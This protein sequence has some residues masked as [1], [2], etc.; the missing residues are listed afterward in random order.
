MQRLRL[1]VAPNPNDPMEDIR[2]AAQVRYDIGAHSPVE[3]DP[4]LPVRR[5]RPHG[6]NRN[7]EREVYFEFETD[8]IEE[9]E[10]VLQTYGHSERV[11][12]TVVEEGEICQNC[13]WVAEGVLPT[14]CRKCG[15]RDI[16]PCPHCHEEVPRQEYQKTSGDL[17]RCPRCGAQVR[18]E[19]NPDLLNANL[20]LNQPVVLVSSV[21][22]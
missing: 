11:K 14:I 6:E 17:F 22:S 4:D 21:G 15:H 5:T 2:Y 3:I 20:T 1:T 7:A 8:L 19:L 10:H 13:G 12:L 18:L 9:V 16:D